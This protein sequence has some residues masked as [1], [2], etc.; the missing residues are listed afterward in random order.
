MPSYIH[1]K[2]AGYVAPL[3]VGGERSILE[4]DLGLP[5]VLGMAGG[6]GF[7]GR[8]QGFWRRIFWKSSIEAGFCRWSGRSFGVAQ[9]LRFCGGSA[10]WFEWLLGRGFG[11]GPGGEVLELGQGARFWSWSG[12]EVL[13]LAQGE[14]LELAQ[15]TTL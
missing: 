12:G 4:V 10:K 8:Q 1:S 3:V 15:R 7:G 5:R 14:V 9:G 2:M 6:R 13:E 11:V